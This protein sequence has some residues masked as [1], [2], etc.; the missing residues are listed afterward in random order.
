MQKIEAQK[1]AGCPCNKI[2]DQYIPPCCFSNNAFGKDTT[3]AQV[4]SPAWY[5]NKETRKWDMPP[6]TVSLW[7]Y[8]EMYYE[9]D[10]NENGTFNYETRIKN[11][12][13]F[14]SEVKENTSLI[15]YY[16]N[17]S[18]PLSGEDDKNMS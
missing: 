11:V 2:S 4:E 13:A 9:D 15:F 8:E 7:P 12:K 6:F 1:Y 3:T 5:A 10:K 16:S 17:Y 14:M 18:N